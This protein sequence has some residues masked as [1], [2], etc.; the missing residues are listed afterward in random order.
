MRL[1]VASYDVLSLQ[2][3]PTA[4]IGQRKSTLL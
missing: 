4:L 1:D 2:Y 3:P